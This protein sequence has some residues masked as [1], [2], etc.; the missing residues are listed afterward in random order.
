MT[1]EKLTEQNHNSLLS[2]RLLIP[3]QHQDD[4]RN[5]EISHSLFPL[6]MQKQ[7]IIK[8]NEYQ[9]SINSIQL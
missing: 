7:F 9:K 1:D 8:N 5:K 4:F 6:S 2:K 3:K